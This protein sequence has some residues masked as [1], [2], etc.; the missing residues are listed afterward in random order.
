MEHICLLVFTSVSA[1]RLLVFWYFFSI[2]V[3]THVGVWVCKKERMRKTEEREENPLLICN[4]LI[5][6]NT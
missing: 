4:R 6:F 3:Y 2:Y 5:T 1:H